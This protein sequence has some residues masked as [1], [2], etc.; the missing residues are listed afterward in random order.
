MFFSANKSNTVD[1]LCIESAMVALSLNLFTATYNELNAFKTENR[2]KT[3]DNKAVNLAAA[4]EQL[5][6]SIQTMTGSFD[7][8]AE[9]QE[10]IEQKVTGGQQALQEAIDSLGGAEK[11]ISN[12]SDVVNN[13]GKRVSEIT[14][15]V[16]I[17]TNIADQTNLLALN[18]AIEAARA[19]EQGRGFSVVA[20]EVRKLAEMSASSAKEIMSYASYLSNG[21]SE[22]LENMKSAQDAVKAGIMS[23]ETASL[24]F[25]EIMKNTKDLT[26]VVVDLT[27]TAQEQTAVTEEV[28]ANASAITSI[29]NFSKEISIETNEH[30]VTMRELFDNKWPGLEKYS[31]SLGLVAFLAQRVVDHSRW[32]DK[33]VDVLSGKIKPSEVKLPDQHN[34]HLGKWYYG[35]GKEVIKRYSSEAQEL[36][37][38]LEEPH[39]Q[40]HQIGL[41]AVSFYENGDEEAA[42]SESMKLTGAARKII[43]TFLKLID[44]VRKESV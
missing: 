36:Y 24:P 18:A 8:V 25:E 32:L 4:A 34:C 23:V 9:D 43:Y 35:E 11:Y 41:A 3:V 20:D 38:M 30:C 29:S 5:S 19:G 40:V 7:Q 44:A 1:N 21:M 14:S 22:T 16:E 15:A 28:A 10:L 31:N 27:G 17:I 6:A 2:V 33:V 39:N 12:L 37:G 13:L 26:D 42:Y